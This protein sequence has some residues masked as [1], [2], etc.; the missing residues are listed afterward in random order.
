LA[1][2]HPLTEARCGMMRLLS[3]G[4]SRRWAAADQTVRVN[5]EALGPLQQGTPKRLVE[6]IEAARAGK[7]GASSLLV[8][9]EITDT[10]NPAYRSKGAEMC[11]ATE[12]IA[13]GTCLGCFR[14]TVSANDLSGA[15][16]DC[17]AFELLD[18]KWLTPSRCVAVDDSLICRINQQRNCHE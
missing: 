13:S 6:C 8:V 10:S 1:S 11:V 16:E 12:D 7:Q 3:Q 9:V 18:G 4:C 15:Y 14:G 2:K 17:F 5:G